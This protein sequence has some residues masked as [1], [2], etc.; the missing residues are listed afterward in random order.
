MTPRTER[1]Q[2]P[3]VENAEVGMPE[4]SPGGVAA[5]R[6]YLF[7]VATALASGADTADVLSDIAR[8]LVRAVDA[9]STYVWVADERDGSLVLRATSEPNPSAVGQFTMRR[10]EGF[11]GWVAEHGEAISIPDGALSDPRARYFPE[12]EEEK[13][14]AMTSVPLV[15]ND[16]TVIG[17]LGLH[18]AA[19]RT[20][21]DDHARLIRDAAELVVAAIERTNAGSSTPDVIDGLSRISLC[22]A[23]AVSLSD[24]LPVIAHEARAVLRASSIDVY[25]VDAGRRICRTVSSPE[26]MP[27]PRSMTVSSLR[28][29][30]TGTSRPAPVDD[31]QG[32][33]ALVTPLEVDGDV[34]GYLVAHQHRGQ[35]LHPRARRIASTIAA[36][37]AVG[38]RK[39]TLE[40]ERS[41]RRDVRPLFD[42]IETRAPE[43]EVINHLRR[44]GADPTQPAFVIEGRTAA[45]Q[46]APHAD[47][48]TDDVLDSLR[49]LLSKTLPRTL[50]DR[51]GDVLRAVLATSSTP[52][53]DTLQ[54][55]RRLL[56]NLPCDDIGIGVSYIC[57]TPGDLSDGLAEANLAARFAA[58]SG[59]S[60]VTQDDLGPYRY[61]LRMES[62]PDDRDPIRRAIRRVIDHDRRRGSDLLRTLELYLHDGA[63]ASVSRKLYVHPNTLRHRLHRIEQISGLDLSRDDRLTIE[64]AIRLV[65]LEDR[66]ADDRR[67]AGSVAGF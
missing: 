55:L 22:V 56:R 43:H 33:I 61:L 59:S 30:A 66:S 48:Q 2:A 44:L 11:A 19:P 53:T 34:L 17:A 7:D 36:Q 29:L 16:G 6:A 15:T 54:R 49:W 27:G 46:P 38:I 14:Q 41:P 25:L 31:P 3:A 23:K 64:I 57:A 67:S 12:F 37:A 10:G 51:D 35:P 58:S 32:G 62:C 45:H 18:A 47:G 24:L 1:L 63:T 60:L 26:G 13:Y 52:G 39:V 5:A 8:A 42:A 9:Q 28:E 50:C 40:Y 21:S 20:L 65:A 4:T